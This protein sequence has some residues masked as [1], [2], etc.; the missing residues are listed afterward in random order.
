MSSWLIGIV[1]AI[2]LTTLI[3]VIMAEGETKK[4]IKGVA[5]LMV[6]AAIIIPLPGLFGAELTWDDLTN[7]SYE[8][9]PETNDTYLN[10]VYESKYKKLEL[11]AQNKM[12]IEGVSGVTVRIN[13]AYGSGGAIEIINVI[14]TTANAV[15][16]G[17]N[18][19]IDI[20]ETALRAVKAT[21]SVPESKIIIN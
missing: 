15:I 3:D 5:S 16:T 4:F 13:I 9:N 12:K 11:A 1:G 14:V 17:E 20:R 18:P 2:V 21:L 10:R 6:I 8:Q 7:N 19:N